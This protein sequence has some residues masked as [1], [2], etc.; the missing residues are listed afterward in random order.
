MK[1]TIHCKR[2][3]NRIQSGYSRT[4]FNIVVSIL[5]LTG[6]AI[7]LQAQELQYSTPSWWFGA[8][9][10][11][12][13]N[14]HRGSIQNLNS[15]FTAP[16]VFDH[17]DGAGLYLA[18]LVEFHNPGSWLG[19][20]FQAGYDNRKGSFKE[21]IASCNCPADLSANLRYITLEP[22]LRFTP[23]RSRF[24]LYAG[25]RLAFTLNKSFTYKQGP[26][27]ATP[28]QD[29]KA[30]VTGDFS[31]THKTLFSAQFGA[32][33][34][35]PFSSQNR[36]TQSVISP[37]VSFQPNLGQSPRSIETWNLT[38]LRVGAAL[39]FGRGRQIPT[40]ALVEIPVPEV[41]FSVN[42]P[43]N[44]PVERRMRESFPVLNYIFFKKGSTE[45]SNSYVLLRRDQVKDFK[46]DQLEVHAPKYL[47]SRSQQE[48][49]VY[50]N[51]LNI[52]G[53]RMGKNAFANIIL[54]GSS[55][56]GPEDGKMM[57][58]SVKRYLVDVFGIHPLRIGIEGRNKPKN[59]SEQPGSTLD[60][61]LL[62]ESDRRVT[63][64][65]YASVLL[66]EFQNGPDAPLKPVEINL[67]QEAPLDS[68]VSFHV[69]G[70][71]EAFTFWSL[72]IRDELGKMQYFKTYTQETVLV[73]GKNILGNRPEGNYK[74]VMVGHT[75]SGKTVT[76]ETTVHMVLWTPAKD[77]QGLRY[78]VIFE[79][80]K[81]KTITIYEK[82]LTDIVTPSIPYGATVL[83]HGYTDIIGEAAYNKTLS[84][85]RA[86]GVRTIIE[87]SLSK[88]GRSDVAIKV[89]GFGEDET[90]SPFENNLPEERS[91]NR[92]VIIDIFPLK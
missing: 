56:N 29:R 3:P 55:E 76:K 82:Y 73:P 37:F 41:I 19:I 20:M 10:G 13:F 66:M 7:L 16:V 35:I 18:P 79:F 15:N 47:S 57:A 5:M 90:L 24:Y 31:N 30:D 50:Y 44:I 78:S 61:E 54:V 89:Y 2:L 84:L 62:R 4:I 38:T 45:I 1:N 27:P 43:K 60:L 14:F 52:L 65:S 58:E 12:N 91:Y 53:D 86:D 9:A 83:I 48:M 33:Y 8:A 69:D 77:E 40:P 75:K 87:N 81:A 49:T 72:E 11:E 25:P 39:K 34:D 6:S 63:I 64:E 92:S 51:V 67:V 22:G 42:S 70:A 21:V 68:Y 74:V 23:F 36:Q 59:P 17:G 88:A 28:D 26:D 71:N 32:G 85:A 46:E 80:D